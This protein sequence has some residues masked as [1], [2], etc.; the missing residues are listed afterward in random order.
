[1]CI[2]TPMVLVSRDGDHGVGRPVGAGPDAALAT[3]DLSLVPDARP[4]DPLLVFLG[5]A[6][7][8]L[9]VEEAGKIALAHRAVAAAMAGE[10]TD[11]AFADLIDREP[12]LPP[13]LEAARIAGRAEG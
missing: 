7:S 1:M 6:R 5:A 4:G 3:I 13:H 2:G 8:R 10:A 12:A 11:F 9:S